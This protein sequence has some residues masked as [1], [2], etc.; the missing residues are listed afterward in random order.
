GFGFCIMDE[1]G[2]VLLHSDAKRNLAEN[3]FVETGYNRKLINSIQLDRNA[4]LS[5]V[6][7]YG[8]AHD[9]AIKSISG[10]P[11]TV[12]VFYARKNIV[13]NMSRF[14]HFSII[15]LVYL[16]SI[17]TLF[18][19]YFSYRKSEP[20]KLQFSL[21]SEE[22]IRPSASNS[23]AYH[24]THKFFSILI[25][26]SIAAICLIQLFRLDYRNILYLS[27]LLPFY[28]FL[29]SIVARKR[30]ISAN[31]ENSLSLIKYGREKIQRMVN[32]SKTQDLISFLYSQ[33]T[34]SLV[35]LVL[36]IVFANLHFIYS[37]CKEN[38]HNCF[39]T[40]SILLLLQI[41]FFVFLIYLFNSSY[42]KL[43]TRSINVVT[44]E[45][46]AKVPNNYLRLLYFAL[47][48]TAIIPCFGITTYA[49]FAEKIQYKK[50]KEL[51][52]AAQFERKFQYLQIQRASYRPYLRSL[53]STRYS[54]SSSLTKGIYL[55]DQDSVWLEEQ[56]SQ[57]HNTGYDQ[58]YQ[59]IVNQLYQYTS[60]LFGEFAIAGKSG[61][62]SSWVFASNSDSLTLFYKGKNLNPPVLTAR[63]FF[64]T[65]LENFMHVFKSGGYIFP[66][67][68]ILFLIFL[69]WCTAS[70]IQRLFL[71]HF[72]YP[73]KADENFL[74]KYLL[75]GKTDPLYPHV[76]GTGLSLS[77]ISSSE[78][79]G[80]GQ[81]ERI[82]RM[83][84]SLAPMYKDIWNDLSEKE[85]FI[86]YDLCRDGYTNYKN[87]DVFYQLLVKGIL[88]YE[89]YKVRPF[90][91]SFRNFV[92][93]QKDDTA[94][95]LILKK[96][97][98]G[99]VWKALKMPVLVVAG[100]IGVFFVLTQ[101]EVAQD[102]TA[103]IT[104]L[105]AIIPL[106]I[107]L[108]GRNTRKEE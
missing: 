19:L 26:V 1:K 75:S 78:D 12:V 46:S 100:T 40:V 16:F 81:E 60:P 53:D 72:S 96:Y 31:E 28:T 58:P 39:L 102:L 44:K 55:S 6:K 15:C 9:L 61:D 57:V 5:D 59:A 63:S 99:G 32:A 92:L 47:I 43:G 94:M 64:Q 23:E 33:L 108:L 49:F 82:L 74:K 68:V 93:M 88:I 69:Y 76:Y 70:L 22:W 91:Y 29:G 34:S 67:I 106:L 17:I 36:I 79:T 42:K 95:Q 89:D 3:F 101:N 35:V 25:I 20:T 83:T 8:T 14:L 85:K 4:L 10:Q 65:P 37:L 73:P 2:D 11:L 71:L 27:I 56:P 104:S 87:A 66:F 62:N 45:A 84:F 98:I 38:D 103:F 77:Q 51:F 107:Q 21:Q 7:L 13:R 30:L 50:T 86:L 52:I 80:P 48:L 41:V 24:F 18:V 90:S 97:A 54:L 105:V